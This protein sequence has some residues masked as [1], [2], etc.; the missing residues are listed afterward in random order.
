MNVLR[1]FR[2]I[3][4]CLNKIFAKSDRMWRREAK[5]FETVDVMHRFEQLDEWTLALHERE[6][7]ASKKIHDLAQER[8]L[9]HAAGHQLTDF[10]HDFFDGA[11][12]LRASRLRHDAKCAMHIAPLH[13][14]DK[15]C[16]LAA[17][18]FVVADRFG[19]AS[20]FLRV[21]N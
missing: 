7:V 16:R 6:F 20:L 1:E 15:R 4:Q 8:H 17:L 11:T 5:T 2:Q 3:G 14:G 9:F 19:G 21:A 10:A 13:D 12:S 18:Q